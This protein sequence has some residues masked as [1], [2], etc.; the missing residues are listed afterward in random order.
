MGIIYI[1]PYH[2]NMYTKIFWSKSH[3]MMPSPHLFLGCVI[4]LSLGPK[5]SLLCTYLLGASH[6]SLPPIN[7]QTSQSLCHVFK[8]WEH[9]PNSSSDN[10]SFMPTLKLEEFVSTIKFWTTFGLCCQI[11]I[12]ILPTK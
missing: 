12:Y 4:S 10:P 1:L 3:Q 9:H 6:H 7:R 11:Y 8:E 5:P 2:H